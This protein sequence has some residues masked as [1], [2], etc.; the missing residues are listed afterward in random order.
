[1]APAICVETDCQCAGQRETRTARHR[2]D[3]ADGVDAISAKARLKT[4][5]LQHCFSHFR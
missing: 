2:A 5:L 4:I 3:A 1:M